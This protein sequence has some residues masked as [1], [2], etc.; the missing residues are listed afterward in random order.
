M[1]P[2]GQPKFRRRKAD[3]PEEIVRSALAVFARKGFAAAKLDDIA[4]EAGISKGA[5]YLYFA[6]KEDIFAAVVEQT[7][8]P[9]LRAIETLANQPRPFVELARAIAQILPAIAKTAPVA[10]IAKMVIGE[11]RN[12]P[13]LARLWHERLVNPIVTAVAGAVEAAQARGELRPADPR[14]CAISLASGLLI[15]LIWNDTFAPLGAEPFDIR[16][17]AHHHIE[18]VL[19][20]LVTDPGALE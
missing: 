5:L 10:G 14:A 4:A 8:A 13:E 1:L 18:T 19:R 6:T 16:A 20:G 9:S 17:L 7:L 11:A 2:T 12:F 3:R 15:G